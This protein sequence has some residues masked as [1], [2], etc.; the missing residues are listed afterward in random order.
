MGENWEDEYTQLLKDCETRSERL[1]DWELQFVDSLG[2]QL[3]QGRRPT[4]KQEA[5]LNNIWEK[6]TSKG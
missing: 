6:A 2:R 4:Q 3:V 5:A 1:N